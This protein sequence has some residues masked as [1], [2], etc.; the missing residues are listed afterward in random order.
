M[1]YIDLTES[2]QLN[3]VDSNSFKGKGVLIFK[4]SSRCIISRMVW[5]NLSSDWSNDLDDLSVYYLDLISYRALSQEVAK[6]YNVHHESP[7][8]L[9]IKAGKCVYNDSHQGIQFKEIQ[10]LVNA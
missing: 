10:S 6:R 3:E 5:S 2:V 8:A 1:D 4:H 7:Q 9:L